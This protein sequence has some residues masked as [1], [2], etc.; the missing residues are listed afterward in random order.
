MSVEHFHTDIV[1]LGAGIGGFET[2]RTLNKLLKSRGIKK[3]I[4]LVDQNDYFTFTPLLHEVAAGIVEPGH[5]ALPL[6]E[7]VSETPHRFIN[8]TVTKVFPDQKIIITDRGEMSYDYCVAGIGSGVNYYGIPGADQFSYNVRTLTEAMRL[9]EELV[10]KLESGDRTI[11]VVVVGGGFSGVEVAG[12]MAHLANHDL[13]KLYPEARISVSLIQ[14]D[15]ALVPL[16]PRRAQELVTKRLEKMKVKIFL[17]SAVKEVAARA[18]AMADSS[19]IPSTMTI[20][21]AGVKNVGEN[22]FDSSFCEKGRLTVTEYLNCAKAPSLYGVGDIISGKNIG[23]T[24]LFPQLGEAAHRQ[25]EYIASHIV[26]TLRKKS[27]RPFYFKSKGILMPIGERYGVAV[28]GPFVF[29]GLIAWWLRRTA[30]VLFMPGLLLKLKIVF[31]WTLRLLGF[32]DIMYVV[33]S[34]KQG[35]KNK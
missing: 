11:D 5:A 16:L 21:C 20:W 17:K 33:T 25:G 12:L 6:R 8:T 22:I 18:I 29:G 15:A 30:Y 27:I 34:N 32:K 31:D 9:Q 1:I 4:T 14:N 2:F 10:R 3:T 23:S 35:T 26:A 7:I 19:A 28:M 24:V 13:Q